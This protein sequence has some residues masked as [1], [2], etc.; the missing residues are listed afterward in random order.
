M[1]AQSLLKFALLGFVA[2][3]L[4]VIVARE[5]VDD[6]Q[7]QA[8]GGPPQLPADGLVAIYFHGDIRCPTCQ[9]IEAYSREAIH[10]NFADELANGQLI[11]QVINYEE[12]QNAHFA[13]EYEI[14]APTVVLVK[15]AAGRDARWQNLG[16]V[17]ELVGDKPAF[18]EYIAAETGPLLSAH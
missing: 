5:L 8:E 4:L 9:T 11:W 17:W 7:A 1:N 3:A 6:T 2:V 15:R 14:A 13:K 16:R 12:T 10:Q 18:V